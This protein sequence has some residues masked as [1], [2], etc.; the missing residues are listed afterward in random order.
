MKFTEKLS[1]AASAS[2]SLLCIGLDPDINLLPKA[3]RLEKF[4]TEIVQSTA[5]LV[6]AYKINF[7]F[8][9]AMGDEG[10]RLLKFARGLI[11]AHIPVIADAKRG[12]IGNTSSAYAKAVFE[13][14]DFDAV[15]V[16]PYMGYD[17]LEPF[18]EYT[19]RQVFILCRTSNPGSA[20]FQNLSLTDGQESI[21]LYVVVA[22]KAAEWNRNGNIGL[23][24]GATNPEELGV[25]RKTNPSML[26]LIPGIGA[27]GGDIGRTVINGVDSSGSGAII[28]SSRQVIHASREAGY[29]RSARNAAL[30]LKDEINQHRANP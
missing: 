29:A 28:S 24:A 18:F 2:N 21:P 22:R 6:C 16:S 1:S 10:Y 3:V 17:S 14:L 27:Q 7:A 25:I 5:D 9:E 12:D 23:V 26:L 4:L 8:F 13:H 15:T 11:P 19:E 30:L 20:D